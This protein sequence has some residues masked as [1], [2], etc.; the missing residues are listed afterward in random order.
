MTYNAHGRPGIVVAALGS[1][2]LL[3]GLPGPA[4][5]Q[6]FGQPN[7][8]QQPGFQQPSFQQPGFQQPGF[9]QPGF[10]QPGFQQP[11]FGQNPGGQ[12]GLNPSG[13]QFAPS[14]VGAWSSQKSSQFGPIQQTD[15]F[16][17]DGRY[18]SVAAWQ[19]TGLIVRVW[20][21]YRASPAGPNQLTVEL[22]MQGSMPQQ[23]CVPSQGSSPLCR[24][25]DAPPQTATVTV[26]FTSPSSFQAIT[27]NDPSAEMRLATREPNPVLLQRQVA[28]QQMLNLPAPA[29][30]P[31]VPSPPSYP[32]PYRSP[33]YSSNPG[34]KCDDGH[35]RTICMIREGR[36]VSSGG[37]LVCVDK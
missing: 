3:S 11:G 23:I 33:S 12:P 37:C 36:L 22:Q 6:G 30:L 24:P 29:P 27:Q 28:P 4:A 35:T 31:Y 21:T 16:S 10:Q 26:T 18:V 5:A 2:I 20:G 9:Q 14:M 7:N 13:A 1:L 32:T 8:G 15:A 25:F 34:P 17:Q 19:Q